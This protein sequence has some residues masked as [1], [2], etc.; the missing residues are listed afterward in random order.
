[1]ANQ[2]RFAKNIRVTSSNCRHRV[3]ILLANRRTT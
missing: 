1:M 3:S 2:R